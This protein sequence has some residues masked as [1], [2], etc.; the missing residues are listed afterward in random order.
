MIAHKK[1][2]LGQYNITFLA[3]VLLHWSCH[4]DKLNL[5]TVRMIKTGR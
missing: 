4:A 2:K 1:I 5:V 3:S